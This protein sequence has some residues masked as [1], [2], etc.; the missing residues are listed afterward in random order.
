MQRHARENEHQYPVQKRNVSQKLRV[1]D[2]WAQ[3]LWAQETRKRGDDIPVV[4]RC[5]RHIWDMIRTHH[6]VERQQDL[7][8]GCI[9]Y[10]CR[11][12]RE[13]TDWETLYQKMTDTERRK[14]WVYEDI[15]WVTKQNSKIEMSQSLYFVVR[16]DPKSSHRVR[17]QTDVM[18]SQSICVG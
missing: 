13:N 15:C 16:Y 9:W 17:D 8:E 7:K 14:S 2:H 1:I 10:H 11:F 5:S 6:Q 4:I 12:H 3:K 18:N